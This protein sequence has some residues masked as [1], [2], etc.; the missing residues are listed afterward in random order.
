MDCRAQNSLLQILCLI[1]IQ[2]E[3]ILHN[4]VTLANFCKSL[5]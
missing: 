2:C 4:F 3:Q 1:C 5:A